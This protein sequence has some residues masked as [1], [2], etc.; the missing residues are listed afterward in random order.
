M[1]ARA[2]QEDYP[3]TPR[4]SD[5]ARTSATPARHHRGWPRLPRDRPGQPS[6]PPDRDSRARVAAP[7]GKAAARAI[8]ASCS[9][10]AARVSA[11]QLIAPTRSA[12]SRM[13]TVGRSRAAA[14][15][16]ATTMSSSDSVAS[17]A[18]WS[19]AVNISFRTRNGRSAR[20]GNAVTATTRTP[21]SLPP[22]SIAPQRGL[23]D[24]RLAL[25]HQPS[26]RERRT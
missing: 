5:G 14:A 15:S 8:G 10:R 21:A 22:A 16:A 6:V 24:A 19:N 7:I 12:S 26:T 1:P 11:S 9:R 25:Q 3:Q 13:R 17:S 20:S 2:E 18:S 4:A 23:A